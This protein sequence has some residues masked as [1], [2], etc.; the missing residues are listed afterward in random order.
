[1]ML[2][3]PKPTSFHILA[4]LSL[5]ALLLFPS[6]LWAVSESYFSN[7][8]VSIEVGIEG[9]ILLKPESGSQEIQYVAANLSFF[10]ES[11]FQQEP[12]S[13]STAPEAA[14]F[15]GILQWRWVS[16][17]AREL[18]FEL[19]STVEVRNTFPVLSGKVPFPLKKLPDSLIPFTLPSPTV[20]ADAPEIIARANALAGG[21]DD[22]FEIV[23]AFASWVKQQIQYDLSTL[24][25]SVSQPASW[26]LEN[27]KGVCDELTNLFIAFNRVLGIPARFVSGLAYTDALP[28]GEGFGPHGWAEVYFPGFGWIPFDVTFGQ[29]GYID[30]FHV[31]LK[32]ALDADE[33]STRYEWL[34]RGISVDTQPLK[35]TGKVIGRKGSPKDPVETTLS[36]A[37]QN[38]RF[39]AFDI[40]EAMVKNLANSYLAVE[41]QLSKS[42]EIDMVDNET[43]LVVLKPFETKK[44]FWRIRVSDAL[45]QNFVYTFPFE[46]RAFGKVAASA[47]LKAQRDSVLLSR[48]DAD[49]LYDELRQESSSGSGS[50]KAPSIDINCKG[51]KAELYPFESAR[52]ECEVAN[53]GVTLITDGRLCYGE[54]C[55]GMQLLLGRSLVRNFTFI[56]SETGAVRVKIKA[57]APGISKTTDV[58][59]NVLDM[60]NIFIAGIKSPSSVMF[61]EKFSIEFTLEKVS[62]SAPQSVEVLIIPPRL[63]WAVDQ[64]AVGRKFDAELKANSLKPGMNKVM[65][66]VNYKDKRGNSYS[67]GSSF[68]IELKGVN[69]WQ[70]T[71]LFFNRLFIGIGSL[72]S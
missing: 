14:S 4:A 17:S 15:P 18:P 3:K 25:E 58:I 29:F 11:N 55:Q 23:T 67:T 22:L 51:D 31:K 42:S 68:E 24:T 28:T 21:K 7:D 13:L 72:M 30:E 6:P 26:V 19:K 43:L 45:D 64:L 2:G 9:K 53:A 36:L 50:V 59:F 32:H 66:K 34:A 54:I 65:I 52:M 27:R 39:G 35:I 5:C 8:A 60:P 38:V 33:P 40:V 10:P 63:G 56:P 47:E 1:M 62:A 20:D 71:F 12:E 57:T 41:L 70:R 49:E 46:V 37:K 61:G 44:V 16:P 48:Q 69:W